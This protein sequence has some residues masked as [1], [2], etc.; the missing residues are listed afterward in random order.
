MIINTKTIVITLVLVVIA[1]VWGLKFIRKFA[2]QIAQENHDAVA[3][4][5][6][7]EEQERLK[8]ARAADA[9]ASVAFAKVENTIPKFASVKVNEQSAAKLADV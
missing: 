2:L 6:Q 3:A 8:K 7:A 5:D 9:A 1:F 4:M